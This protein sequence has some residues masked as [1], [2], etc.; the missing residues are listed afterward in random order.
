MIPD[1]LLANLV[2]ERVVVVIEEWREDCF[3]F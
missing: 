2:E 1:T 3:I